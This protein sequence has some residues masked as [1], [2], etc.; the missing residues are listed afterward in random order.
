MPDAGTIIQN[1]GKSKY[2]TTLDLESGFQILLKEEDRE[3]PHL[4]LMV[5]YKQIVSHNFLP[6]TEELIWIKKIEI[7]ADQLDEHRA[8]RSINFLGSYLKFITGTPDRDE[9][10]QIESAINTLI[11]NNEKPESY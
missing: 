9:T 6:T 2:F 1:L 10:I 4:V 8:K 5:P 7:L 11:N 3:K